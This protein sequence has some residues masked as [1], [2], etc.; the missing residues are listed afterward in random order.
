MKSSIISRDLSAVFSVIMTAFIA[1]S[2]AGAATVGT[3][4]GGGAG[5][6]AGSVRNVEKGPA[7]IKPAAGS[8]ERKALLEVLRVPV[9]K[10][11]D[12]T[13]AEAPELKGE[14]VVFTPEW[15][16]VSG[17]WAYVSTSFTPDFAEGVVSA[18][19]Q[20][21]KAGWVVKDLS[22]ADDLPNYDALA[23][24]FG[25]ARGIFPKGV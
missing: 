11:C 22:W 10:S 17:D 12:E 2:A 16:A 8:A 6:P 1:A 19:M 18:V 21:T 15:I 24:K 23:K 3:A 14:K 25:A 9:Q 20:R 7:V 4:G 5:A 13:A